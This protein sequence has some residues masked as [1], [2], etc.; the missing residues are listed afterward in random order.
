MD[1]D[2]F[3]P[4]LFCV[5]CSGT[6]LRQLS[7]SWKIKYGHIGSEASSN[8]LLYPVWQLEQSSTLL[9]P[10][11][12]LLVLL[13]CVSSGVVQC[14][15]HSRLWN[16]QEA[17]KAEIEMP[18]PSQSFLSVAMV[19]LLFRPLMRLLTVDCVTSLR[20][21]SL[22]MDRS[23]CSHNSKIRFLTASPIVIQVRLLK[24]LIRVYLGIKTYIEHSIFCKTLQSRIYVLQNGLF[25][26]VTD[27]IPPF[28]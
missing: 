23:C 18:K 13:K 3:F 27:L 5:N 10:I 9:F 25:A 22:L 4:S 26:T 19:M 20:A 8:L 6:N 21:H 2:A 1:S 24:Q 16:R 12:I 17:K 7:P 11:D 14:S 28:K 15:R